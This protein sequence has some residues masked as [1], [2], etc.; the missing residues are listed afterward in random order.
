MSDLTVALMVWCAGCCLPR[1]GVPPGAVPV[2]V[3]EDPMILAIE[4]SSLDGA[5]TASVGRYGSRERGK[6]HESW[7]RLEVGDAAVEVYSTRSLTWREFGQV[8][9]TDDETTRFT[10]TYGEHPFGNVAFTW[11]PRGS[12]ALEPTKSV[13]VKETVISTLKSGGGEYQAELVASISSID[14]EPHLALRLSGDDATLTLELPGDPAASSG[15]WAPDDSFSLMV[16]DGS[17]LTVKIGV[18]SEGGDTP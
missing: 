16:G 5:R 6:V 11:S 13:W 3:D 4:A 9:W 8:I 15:A 17:Q 18:T 10:H 14:T 1:E 12:G 2:V 7:S